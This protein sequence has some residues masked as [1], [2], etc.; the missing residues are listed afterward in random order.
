MNALTTA[1]LGALDLAGDN[2]AEAWSLIRT[3]RHEKHPPDREAVV[4]LAQ[5]TD[6]VLRLSTGTA[7]DAAAIAA[8]EAWLEKQSC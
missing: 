8:L 4:L 6:I 7:D 3:A 5:A 2:I 1:D